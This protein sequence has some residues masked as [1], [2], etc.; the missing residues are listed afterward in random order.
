MSGRNITRFKKGARYRTPI[1][2]SNGTISKIVRADRNAA[3]VLGALHGSLEGGLERRGRGLR[4]VAGGHHALLLEE[5]L[6]R[7]CYDV[8]HRDGE[9]KIKTEG[10]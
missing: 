7:R 1:L 3:V 5:V 8:T 9:K 2:N 6:D 4:E 10:L